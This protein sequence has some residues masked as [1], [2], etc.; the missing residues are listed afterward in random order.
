[1]GHSPLPAV[2]QPTDRGIRAR[3]RTTI[4][5][6]PLVFVIMT[7]LLL[8]G[9]VGDGPLSWRTVRDGDLAV[10]YE[11]FTRRGSTWTMTVEVPT[12]PDGQ[13]AVRVGRSLHQ[14]FQ[15]DGI[16]PQP[17]AVRTDAEWLV[18]EFA[19]GRP[20]QATSI[21]FHVTA[22]ALWSQQGAIR[23]T[24]GQQVPVQQFIYP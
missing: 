15:I 2:P 9:V 17:D 13:T 19:G 21:E 16:E 22:D 6:A 8:A 24:N 5:I 3:Q 14:A 20:S 23:G 1:M 10:S 4:V 12:G 11:R 7:L 18:Y